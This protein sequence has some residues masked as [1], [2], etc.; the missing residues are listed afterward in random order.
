[1]SYSYEIERAKNNFGT[2]GA[3]ELRGHREKVHTVGWNCD[4][5]RLAS[6]SVDQTA[7]V[8]TLS[9]DSA[10]SSANRDSIELKGHHGDVDQLCWDP[11]H[12]DKLATA[13][14]DKSVRLWDVRAHNRAAHTISTSGEN[15][16]IV[17]SPDGKT[18]AV[19][20]KEDVITFIDPRSVGDT[21]KGV[22]KTLA[23]DVEINEISWNYSSDL[24]FMSTGQGTIRILEYPSLRHAYT[25]NAHTANCYCLE[26]DPRGRYFATGSADAIVSLWD[27][28]DYICLRTFGRLDWPV[29]TI[30][31]SYDGE[32]LASGSEDHLIDISH[33]E[34]GEHV[35]T[36]QCS[37]AMNTVAWHPSKL[38][39]AYA[40]DEVVNGRPEGN[41]RIFGFPKSD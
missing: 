26:F 8:W 35:H 6:G 29:R 28:E 5:R 38:L 14:V 34:T 10:S 18:I 1:M 22:I 13:S 15:I 20:N 2:M 21:K 37:A 36:I 40:G 39:L 24:F 33:V 25:V 9:N 3:R 11:T 30:S 23:N 19:G 32:Y 17:W 41:L 27:L 31:F 16:N 7:R 4:G 12:P